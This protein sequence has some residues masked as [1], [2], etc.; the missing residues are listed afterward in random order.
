MDRVRNPFIDSTYETV[1]FT[2]DEGSEQIDVR[3][4]RILFYYYSTQN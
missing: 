4:D 3:N 2:T 1:L